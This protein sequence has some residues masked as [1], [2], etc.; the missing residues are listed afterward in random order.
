V[1]EAGLNLGFHL[2]PRTVMRFG[3][4]FVY[5]SNVLRPGDQI[6]RVVSP[7]LV[8][9]DPNYG[10]GGPNQPAYQFHAASYWAQGLNFGLEFN[11]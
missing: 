6:S 5:W 8:P 11:F 10:T 3:Y 7:S 2:S 9:T 4:T 1:P